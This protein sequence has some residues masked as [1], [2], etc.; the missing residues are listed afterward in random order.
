MPGC[1]HLTKKK[2]SKD[3]CYVCNPNT[4]TMTLSA[5]SDQ[6]STGTGK[7]LGPFWKEYTTTISE[8]L[9]LPT[10]TDY[11]G[12][13]SSCLNG[14]LKNI[15]SNSWYSILCHKKTLQLQQ[16]NW[17]KTYSQSLPTL[18]PK[19]TV[20]EQVETGKSEKRSNIV[21]MHSIKLKPTQQQRKV[22]NDWIGA[23]RFFYNQCVALFI[24]HGKKIINLSTLRDNLINT[25]AL[26]RNGWE[27]AKSI[28]YDV[29]DEALRDFR[30]A[31]EINIRSKKTF[32][33]KFKSRKHDTQC[34]VVLKKHWGHKKGVYA[35][36]NQIPSCEPIPKSL[37]IDSRIVKKNG[38]FWL[39][40]AQCSSHQKDDLTENQGS[41]RFV[42]ALD[43]GIRTFMTGYD[44]SGCVFEWGRNDYK[45]LHR[46]KS[47]ANKLQGL[48][49]SKETKCRK[50]AKLKKA[51][52]RIMYKIDNLVKN[53]HYNLI[54]FLTSTYNAII[55]PIFKVKEMMSK[56]RKLNKK[57]KQHLSLWSHFQFRRRLKDR[58]RLTGSKVYV[59]TEEYTSRTC[60]K[61]GHLC[62]KSSSKLKSCECCSQVI[63]RDLNGARNILM[64]S[65]TGAFESSQKERC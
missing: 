45:R 63:D 3:K 49:A 31:V 57:S 1:H 64:K 36:L 44:P 22:L 48:I 59:V 54:K 42:V 35:F 7:V 62:P 4:Q 15:K 10:E 61:C 13:D 24:Q 8:K 46:L 14:S 51:R 47:C 17:L 25:D 29:K 12:L 60:T 65:L 39:K 2:T 58:A 26:D 20:V 27:W 5:T 11:V 6:D 34:L 41:R 28:P 43:P 52:A 33:M 18:L 9:W 19:I 53:L 38:M 23:F 21:G 30:K 40:L 50:R 16:E 32:D 37:P 56:R 55:I